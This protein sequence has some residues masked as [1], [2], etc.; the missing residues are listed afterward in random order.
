MNCPIC[1][2]RGR[3][4]KDATVSSLLTPASLVRRENRAALVYSFCR[5]PECA[6]VYF[7]EDGLA[8]TTDDLRVEVYQKSQ[9]PDRLVCY[10]FEH[11][12]QSIKDDI[13]KTGNA[14]ALTTIAHRCKSNEDDCVHKNP[15][16]A[17]CLGNI[18]A[19]VDDMGD[20]D[21]IEDA[22]SL[23]ETTNDCG[24]STDNNACS[25]EDN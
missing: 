11:T 7:T 2:K 25:I 9:N 13:K 22:A 17:C 4:I 16:G 18:R 21:I 3:R 20:P 10:C 5:Q 1:G 8:F 12:V 6:I 24:C 14:S 23:E 15:Q 19:I